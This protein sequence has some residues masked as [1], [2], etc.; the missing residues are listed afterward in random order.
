MF[1]GFWAKTGNSTESTRRRLSEVAYQLS[2]RC[3]NCGF[4]ECC[5]VRAVEKESVALLNLSR[6]EQKALSQ[7]GILRLEDLA[8]LKAVPKPDDQRPYNFK[9]IPASDLQKVQALSA[10]PVIGSKLDKLIQRAQF[11]L[12]G[13]D[14]TARLQTVRAMPWLTGTGTE[15]CQR[16]APNWAWTRR[17]RFRP[18]GMIRVYFHV[19][20]D[21]MQDIVS[22]ISA[23]SAARGSGANQ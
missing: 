9:E 17:F 20:W 8:R 19:E 13:L 15:R 4:N 3:D 2:W 16:T 12:Y 11:M 10:D 14:P 18:D 22:M 1:R 21:Y 6:G 5:I 7:H 23:R